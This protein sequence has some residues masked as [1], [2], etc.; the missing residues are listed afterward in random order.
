MRLRLEMRHLGFDSLAQQA[1]LEC[2]WAMEGRAMQAGARPL[3]Q[4]QQSER[5][6]VRWCAGRGAQLT[7]WGSASHRPV[8]APDPLLPRPA[9]A[10]LSTAAWTAAGL[11]CWHAQ[12]SH[13]PLPA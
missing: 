11:P 10:A 8:D 6:A 3:A 13:P 2:R 1:L 5:D 12:Q 9:P 7:A 4:L